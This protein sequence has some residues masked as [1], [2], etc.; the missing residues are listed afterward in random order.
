MSE[1][2]KGSRTGFA[3]RNRTLGSVETLF[4]GPLCGR[5][6]T[7]RSQGGLMM[8]LAYFFQSSSSLR[9]SQN[10]KPAAGRVVRLVHRSSSIS[11]RFSV[12]NN[13]A[14]GR[15]LW[16]TSFPRKWESSVPPES[17]FCL[18]AC[19]SRWDGSR[20]LMT[21]SRMNFHGSHAH[22]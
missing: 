15:F 14:K 18:C 13:T 1:F 17:R 22:Q 8:G 4:I 7:I 3:K 20:R 12:I 11:C 19:R 21:N 6:F 2:L 10:P 5:N 9:A 16:Q